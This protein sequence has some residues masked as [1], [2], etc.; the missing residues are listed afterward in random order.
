MQGH[1]LTHC[2]TARDLIYDLNDE[3]TIKWNSIKP[4]GVYSPQKMPQAQGP[5]TGTTQRVPNMQIYINPMPQ[6]AASTSTQPLQEP[7]ANVATVSH[8]S[9]DFPIQPAISQNQP[10]YDDFFEDDDYWKYVNWDGKTKFRLDN[11]KTGMVID[12]PDLYKV[13]FDDDIVYKGSRTSTH[14]QF[15]HPHDVGPSQAHL[16]SGRIRPPRLPP[17]ASAPDPGLQIPNA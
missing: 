6:H 4:M 10:Y 9:T 2:Y 12:S 16:R 11:I 1:D 3:G 15:N 8:Q 7:S 13:F 5:L 17:I 14:S